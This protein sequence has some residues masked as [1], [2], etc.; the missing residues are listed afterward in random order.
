MKQ[1]SFLEGIYYLCRL[2]A[3][4]RAHKLKK[5]HRIC[6]SCSVTFPIFSVT[7]FFLRILSI[8][9]IYINTAQLNVYTHYTPE[10]SN[11]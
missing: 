9:L 10:I 4:V 6:A 8:A 2:L 11:K 5:L 3:L 7:N 1:S